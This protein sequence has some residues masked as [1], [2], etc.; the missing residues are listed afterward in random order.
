[1]LNLNSLMWWLD[2]YDDGSDGVELGQ[3][4]LETGIDVPLNLE[5]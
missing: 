1:M 2:S 5:C 3:L 4:A